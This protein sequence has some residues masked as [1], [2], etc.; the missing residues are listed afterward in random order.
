[1]YGMVL[2]DEMFPFADDRGSWA[3]AFFRAIETSLHLL[4]RAPAFQELFN[5][6]DCCRATLSSM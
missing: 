3:A 6:A 4:I 1:M 5:F 2:A